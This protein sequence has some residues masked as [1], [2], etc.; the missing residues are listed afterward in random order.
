MGY[1]CLESSQEAFHCFALSKSPNVDATR[2]ANSETKVA[3]EA[4][5]YAQRSYNEQF[6]ETLAL[7]L[8]KLQRPGHLC[9]IMMRGA[10]LL[11]ALVAL[12]TRGVAGI[13][14]G[15]GC[16]ERAPAAPPPWKPRDASYTKSRV[17]GVRGGSRIA[18]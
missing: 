6:T 18:I 13:T 12:L 17:D 16:G 3:L 9:Y 10:S 7:E 8:I 15:A 5:I 4:T 2:P 11:L 1:G 14:D